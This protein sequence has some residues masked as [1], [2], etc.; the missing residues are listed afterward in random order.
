[1]Q[2][3]NFHTYIDDSWSGGRVLDKNFQKLIVSNDGLRPI[4]NAGGLIV[5]V[6]HVQ[7]L[8]DR[9]TLLRGKIASELGVSELPELHMRQL[10]GARPPHDGGKNPYVGVDAETRFKFAKWAVDL[11]SEFCLARRTYIVQASGYTS[12]IIDSHYNFHASEE[13]K[14]QNSLIIGHFGGRSKNFYNIILNPLPGLIAQAMIRSENTARTLGGLN[15]FFYDAPESSKSFDI[16][17]SFAIARSIR[18]L[19]STV[20]LKATNT[21]ETQLLQLADVVSYISHRRTYSTQ[22]GNVDI[23]IEKLMAGHKWHERELPNNRNTESVLR[24]CHSVCLMLHYELGVEELK[25]IDAAW[26]AKNLLDPR[27]LLQAAL[28]SYPAGTGLSLLRIK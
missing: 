5:K 6:S 15:H 18:V 28:A 14:R 9:L 2:N 27:E 3:K 16:T 7:N 24:N 10:W 22:L 8:N 4:I 19:D 26:V 11:I 1:M 12:E 13:G 20:S 21:R 25:K 17:A 23:G